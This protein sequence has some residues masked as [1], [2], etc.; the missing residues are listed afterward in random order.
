MSRKTGLGVCALVALAIGGCPPPAEM[1]DTGPTPTD[2][3]AR[4]DTRVGRDSGPMTDVLAAYRDQLNAAITAECA[5]NWMA[6][7]D[8]SAEACVTRRTMTSRFECTQMGYNAAEAT[9]A[10]SFRCQ[11]E[12]LTTYLACRTAAACTDMTAVRACVDAVNAA[13]TAC[14]DVPDA[15]IEA[16]RMCIID[17]Y[18]GPA[19][20]C[21]EAGAT[22]MGAGTFTGVTTLG[23][24]DFQSGPTCFAMAQDN[25]ELSPDRA[26][27]WI[28]PTP[29]VYTIDTLGTAFDSVL[30]VRNSCTDTAPIACN[31][32]IDPGVMRQS[33]I[34]VT[35]TMP[36]QE[37]IIVVDGFFVESS[38]PFTVHVS[39]PAPLP[40]AGVMPDAGRDAGPV[41]DAGSDAGAA[42]AGVDAFVPPG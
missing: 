38:G 21:P 35:A 42:D 6:E 32:D 11:T 31:D 9:S 33:R 15:Y 26:Y 3:G 28:A 14:P 16:A 41:S 13:I 37:F 29:G 23:G 10:P 40:D 25:L 8:A 12:A 27:R 24:D 4:P 17:N 39:T 30:S 1:T 34:T 22:W 5:C 7:M 19:S 36:N 2:T 18:I 20:A